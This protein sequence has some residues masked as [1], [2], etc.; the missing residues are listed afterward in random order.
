MRAYRFR[1]LMAVAAAAVG[2]ACGVIG[3]SDDFVEIE[4]TEWAR[5]VHQSVTV[6]GPC[7]YQ[8]PVSGAVVSTSLDSKTTATDASGKFHL[9]TSTAIEELR[10]Q[11]VHAHDHRRRT[12]HL[13]QVRRLR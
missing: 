9:V 6:A 7:T 13:Q 1:I 3:P 10:L 8:E 4:G 12:S 2:A 5:C 11:G